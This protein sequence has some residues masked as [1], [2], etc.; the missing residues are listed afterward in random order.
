MCPGCPFNAVLS[1]EVQLFKVESTR[2]V[3]D[4]AGVPSEI[5]QVVWRSYAEFRS[6]HQSLL[7]ETDKFLTAEL[8]DRAGWWVHPL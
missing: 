6:L 7:V 5:K 2:T 1:P 3:N 8:P 4:A